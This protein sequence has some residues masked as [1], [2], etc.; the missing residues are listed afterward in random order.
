[1]ALAFVIGPA[2]GMVADFV[3]W[4]LAPARELAFGSLRSA[5]AGAASAVDTV[6]VARVLAEQAKSLLDTVLGSWPLS[7]AMG[8][9]AFMPVGMLTVWKLLTMVL[10]RV[11]WV[12]VEDPLEVQDQDLSP[13]TPGPL[14]LELFDVR[15]RYPGA[16]TDALK[17]VSLTVGEREFIVLTGANGSGKSTLVRVLAGAVPTA[18]SVM[19]P[20]APGIGAVGGTA[21]IL[22]RPEAQVLGINVAEDLAWGLPDGFVPDTATVLAAVG[23]AGMEQRPTSALSGG[24][25]QR[26]AI[27]SALVR[28]PALLISDESTAMIDAEG[29]G[30]LLE[31]LAQLPRKFP[32]TVLHVSHSGV[33]ASR[34]DRVIHLVNGRI[35]APGPD[36]P[37]THSEAHP[38]SGS[39]SH[40]V[41]PEATG[42]AP[43]LE[44][45]DVGHTYAPGTPWS[46]EAL[47][48]LSFELGEGEGLA[49]TG[50][51]GSGK[52][53]LAWI[54]A[55]LLRPERG[56]CLLDG[57]PVVQQQG[58]VALAFQHSRLQVQR[59]T[60]GLDILAAAGRHV[61]PKAGPTTDDRAFVEG[62]LHTVGLPA[63][64]ATRSIEALSGGQLRRVALAGLIAAKP[65]V[66]VLDEPLAG[67]DLSSRRHLGQTLSLLRNRDSMSLI[68]ISHD[69]E[70]L[71]DACPRRIDLGER[72]SQRQAR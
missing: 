56:V 16:G 52:S 10:A 51:N 26:L 58:A 72:V 2:C 42:R 66:L 57:R 61:H 65:R 70:D 23:L 6:P 50:E 9:T 17:G 37:V 8:V 43:V 40:V 34:A 20:G 41:A 21:L 27:A 38:G 68:V 33:E 13:S 11:D 24:Q 5:A 29:R 48:P 32:V 14:L 30:S 35:A 28:K 3:L 1:M 19:R 22:Q 25:L 69:L 71:W 18:G 45:Q 4:V 53:T 46:H 55:G 7:V 44:L 36:S 62:A 64:L 12:R 63:G 15:Y 67:L 59:P 31:L 54:L 49:I 60:V 47:R 39:A